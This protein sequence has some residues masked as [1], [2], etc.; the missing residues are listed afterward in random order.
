LCSTPPRTG[1]DTQTQVV[2]PVT[3]QV[4][5]PMLRRIVSSGVFENPP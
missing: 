2:T 3:T 5:I 1:V 4:V